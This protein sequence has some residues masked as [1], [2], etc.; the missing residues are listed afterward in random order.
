KNIVLGAVLL[1][2]DLVTGNFDKLKTD[3][4]QIWENIKQSLSDAWESIKEVF[5]NALTA[6]SDLLSNMWEGM[7]ST[8]S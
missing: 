5:N 3:A 2:L 8:A 6:I 7:K 4:I 1:I